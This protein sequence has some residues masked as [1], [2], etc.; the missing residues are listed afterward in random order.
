MHI[1][2]PGLELVLN[3]VANLG[4]PPAL[5]QLAKGEGQALCEA[6]LFQ[7][8]QLPCEII[9][10]CERERKSV[11]ERERTDMEG[12]KEEIERGEAF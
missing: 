8:G 6:R 7:L 5:A 2:P 10:V 11:C 12:D 1:D 3:P 9:R 4:W